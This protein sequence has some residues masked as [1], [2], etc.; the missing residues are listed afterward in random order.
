LFSRQC[1]SSSLPTRS[2][3]LLQEHDWRPDTDTPTA[4]ES[5]FPAAQFLQNESAEFG[6]AAT[7]SRDLRSYSTSDMDAW[8]YSAYTSPLHPLGST[9]IANRKRSY[10]MANMKPGVF[11]DALGSLR[12]NITRSTS[13][14]V[15]THVRSS[16]D[17]ATTF[18][19]MRTVSRDSTASSKAL[20][21]ALAAALVN[22]PLP[23]DAPTGMSPH[24]R[25]MS[26][27]S[28][29]GRKSTRSRLPSVLS[30]LDSDSE[31]SVGPKCGD[32]AARF[33]QEAFAFGYSKP[34]EMWPPNPAA[35]HNNVSQA[36][37]SS[38]RADSLRLPASAPLDQLAS[39]PLARMP[40]ASSFSLLSGASQ[41]SASWIVACAP[42]P[43]PPQHVCAS[44]L[45]SDTSTLQASFD[46][47]E[48]LT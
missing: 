6:L 3:E 18:S 17:T 8:A 30:P 21:D 46:P 19:S 33:P 4:P 43:L 31:D 34:H 24:F 42:A 15:D 44:P 29:P 20:T 13:D 48:F 47:D 37:I 9:A 28:T 27:S 25:A 26:M 10:S 36:H 16:E 38:S 39:L 41:P 32:I 22:G 1:F 7:T 12:I 2:C 23:N 5:F 14:P 45:H 35:L 11:P 40:H